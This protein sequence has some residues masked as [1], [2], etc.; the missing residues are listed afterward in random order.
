MIADFG[1]GSIDYST[2]FAHIT[3]IPLYIQTL[4]MKF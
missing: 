4:E 1:S 3:A 2:F